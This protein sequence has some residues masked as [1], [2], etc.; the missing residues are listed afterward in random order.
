M[1]DA[2]VTT[3]QSVLEALS[4]PSVSSND[5][6][7]LIERNQV[8]AHRVIKLANSAYFAGRSRVASVREAIARV[9]TANLVE[10]VEQAA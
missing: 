9:G 6:I 7:A 4:D 10:V 8:L 3:V 2:P 1:S 5:L